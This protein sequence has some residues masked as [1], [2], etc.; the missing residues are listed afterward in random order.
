M[1]YHNLATPQMVWYVIVK[2]V[3]KN[4]FGALKFEL[5]V[6]CGTVNKCKLQSSGQV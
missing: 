1:K 3:F 6:F 2:V 5:G 4:L